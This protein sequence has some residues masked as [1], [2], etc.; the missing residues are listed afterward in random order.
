[1]L[2]LLLF[3]LIIILVIF[4]HEFGHFIVA[5][6]CGMRVEEFGFGFPPRIFKI[7]RGETTYSL[8]ALPL[9]GFVKILGEEG[10]SKDKRSFTEKSVSKRIAVLVAGVAMNFVLAIILLTIGFTS[11]MMPLATNP[12]NLKGAKSTEIYFTDVMPK[13]VAEQ[14]DIK[15]GD[16]VL[17]FNSVVEFQ[18]FT[19]SNAAKPVTLKIKRD[20]SE[21]TKSITLGEGDSPLGVGLVAITSVKQSVP[22]AFITATQDTYYAGKMIISVIGRSLKQLVVTGTASDEIKQATGPIGVYRVTG[23]VAKM[24]VI[25][26]L[27][28]IALLSINLGLINILPFPALDG[29]RVVFVLIEGIFRKKVIKDQIE[30]VIH[31]VG[32][33]LLI[34]LIILITLRDIFRFY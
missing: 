28:F 12:E 30:N 3:I 21:I 18:N 9:G 26:F 1:M 29:G 16:I 17:G 31:M 15:P 13:S 24:G 11:G 4:V 14:A 33:V 22:R 2:T 6:L 25:Y 20:D 8:N 34:A 7:K 19:K 32:F 5:K 27:Q 23:Q 10:G